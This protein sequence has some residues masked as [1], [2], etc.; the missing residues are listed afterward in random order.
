MLSAIYYHPNLSLLFY[1]SIISMPNGKSQLNLWGIMRTDWVD[2]DLIQAALK[3]QQFF[4]YT[5]DK[6]S[7][8]LHQHLL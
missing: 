8:S 5:K 4:L 7:I 3:M 1:A 2:S 6:L